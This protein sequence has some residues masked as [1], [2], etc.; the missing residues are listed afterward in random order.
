MD[1][2]DPVRDDE[3][4]YRSVRGA[5]KDREY[6]YDDTESL[7]ITSMAFRDKHKKPSVDRAKLR[8][9]NPALSKLKETD[10]LVS[11]IAGDV[12]AIGD[13]KTKTE[14]EDVIHA[15]DVAYAPTPENPAHA[16]ITVNPEFLGSQ[17]KKRKVFKLLQRALA[18]LATQNGWTLPPGLA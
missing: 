18:R 7:I 13:V 5:L 15:V 16:Q 8:G 12:R 10:G 17:S 11:L 9:F 1:R 6:R 3:V 2:D 14:D 4:L